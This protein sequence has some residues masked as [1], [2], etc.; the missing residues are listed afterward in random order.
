MNLSQGFW[1]L[2]LTLSLVLVMAGAAQIPRPAWGSMEDAAIFYDELKQ[3][4]EW[5]DYGN[6]GPVWYPTQVQ[7]NWR[8][9][10]DGRWTPSEEGH[11]FETQEPWGYA[12]YHYGNWMPTQEYGWVWVPGRTW[13][14]NTVSWRTS[15]ES[16]S[17]DT[18]YIGWAP[19][20]PPNYEPAPGYYPPNY[21]GGSS[22][23]G[24]VDSLISS[25]FW[26]FVKAASFLL[27]FSSPYTPSYSYW[28]CNCL[29]P[30]QAVP[31][32]YNRTVIVNNY[33]TPGYY[34][35]GYL[36]G[37]GYYN[38]GPSIPYVA[39]VTRIH[40]GSIN[41]YMRQVNI[42]QRRNVVP[43]SAVL[44]R[45]AHFRDVMPPAMLNNQPLALGS[46][47]QGGRVGR[48]N[49]VQP[50]LVNANVIKNAPSLSAGI[51]KAPVAGV[52]SGPW[53]RGVPGAALPSSAMVRPN[54][55]MERHI[56]NIPSSQRLEPVSPSARK[57]TV[58][59]ATMSRT[60]E[61]TVVQPAPGLKRRG[62]EVTSTTPGAP[63]ITAPGTGTYRRGPQGTP[64]TLAPGQATAPQ[65]TMG[66]QRRKPTPEGLTPGSPGPSQ[67]VVPR[68][69]SKPGEYQP[70]PWS[71]PDQT[72]QGIATPGPSP[73]QKQL[74]KSPPGTLPAP[75]A[76][77]PQDRPQR[78]LKA[79]P[80]QQQQLQQQQQAP[81]QPPPQM[82][83]QPQPQPQQQMQ[84]HRQPPPQPQQVQRQP[85]TMSQ[86]QVHQQPQRQL[87]AQP[88]SRP[89][90]PQKQQD[91]KQNQQLQ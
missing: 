36:A 91:K 12:T 48:A 69:K 77:T 6:Y 25:P 9:Y 43:P 13:Y 20:P 22:Y 73:K 5:V 87:Q 31:Y 76:S 41:N 45:H 62:P 3:Q 16:Q 63:G 50:N 23:G 11:V 82:H 85:K 24:P 1:K 88:Q 17:P 56:R 81:F 52:E 83:R 34:P 58:P 32:Y 57:W 21:S 29:V 51:P 55:Q 75:A 19:I 60:P 71:R 61:A 78:R 14:P 28:G 35:A 30:V 90:S 84:M 53:R 70:G 44:A 49:L 4:G 42:Y 67:A 15:P 2:A 72:P 89:Q 68:G 39:R 65:E 37:G 27:G 47:F 18:S 33:Y 79:Q 7:E 74:Q 8:P 26:V 64:P 46:R 66:R 86:P 54:Q 38:W 80:P 40:Q 59:Q 10:V